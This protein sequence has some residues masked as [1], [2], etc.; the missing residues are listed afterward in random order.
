MLAPWRLVVFGK[1]DMV[2]FRSVFIDKL[3]INLPV[4]TTCS[5]HSCDCLVEPQSNPT[6][7]IFRQFNSSKLS[8]RERISTTSGSRLRVDLALCRG[9]FQSTRS[10]L[11][12]S[13]FKS[14]QHHTLSGWRHWTIDSCGDECCFKAERAHYAVC[15]SL[16]VD[17]IGGY[18]VCCES[19]DTGHCETSPIRRRGNPVCGKV[20]QARQG[21][22]PRAMAPY[23]R[24]N[25]PSSRI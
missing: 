15:N 7:N 6:Q 2:V 10:N 11:Q 22:I 9:K 23:L 5:K 8:S 18:L 20:R 13:R 14:G 17:G 21:N 19:Q 1:R 4:K 24:R 12:R 3:S 16:V 25:A